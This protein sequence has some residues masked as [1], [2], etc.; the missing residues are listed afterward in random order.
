MAKQLKNHAEA[1]RF[2]AARAL[3]LRLTPL[4]RIEL[5]EQP[6]DDGAVGQVDITENRYH[7]VVRLGRGFF[8]ASADE[9][10]DTI[11][12]ELVHCMLSSLQD[13]L[14]SVEKHLGPGEWAQLHARHHDAL[15]HIT[16]HLAG[17]LTATL[18]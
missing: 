8:K 14:D 12:H 2:L 7:A 13:A 16:D 15:E 9:Q 17:V 18:D 3:Q 10:A 4:W 11:N 6:A 1:R 5:S